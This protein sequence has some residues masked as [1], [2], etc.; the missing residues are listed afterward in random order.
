MRSVDKRIVD[1]VILGTV[2]GAILGEPF[3]QI[4]EAKAL[5]V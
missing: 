3:Q 4:A 2:I 5:L 1:Q